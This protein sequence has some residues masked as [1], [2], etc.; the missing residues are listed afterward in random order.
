MRTKLNSF[1]FIF[2]MPK[3]TKREKLLAE[4]HRSS[5]HPSSVPVAQ[6]ASADS[7]KPSNT[8]LFSYKLP[9]LQQ[10]P[11]NQHA[12]SV[13][14]T[15]EFSSIKKDILKTVLLAACAIVI[16]LLLYWKIGK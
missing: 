2:G 5:N 10:A 7:Q 12:Y 11:I 3:R 9:S 8:E 4:K 1:I 16:E 14:D 13:V 6:T 15:A